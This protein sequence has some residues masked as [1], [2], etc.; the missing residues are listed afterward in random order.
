[1]NLLDRIDQAAAGSDMF[2]ES[3][4]VAPMWFPTDMAV[5]DFIVK[6]TGFG[7]VERA[8]PLIGAIV[9]TLDRLA[10]DHLLVDLSRDGEAALERVYPD[11]PIVI[12]GSVSSSGL[13][14]RRITAA[15]RDLLPRGELTID[16]CEHDQQREVIA[17]V[18]R[19]IER[20]SRMFRGLSRGL[21]PARVRLA[22][23]NP[24]VYVSRFGG[25][26]TTDALQSVDLTLDALYTG[27]AEAGA[28]AGIDWKNHRHEA[29]RALGGLRVIGDLMPDPAGSSL[30]G[31]EVPASADY[32]DYAGFVDRWVAEDEAALAAADPV[33]SSFTDFADD[34]HAALFDAVRDALSVVPSVPGVAG[35]RL[36]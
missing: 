23:L 36:G 7:A 18:N 17:A 8:R 32:S 22:I 34:R 29:E 9:E 25:V 26:R 3:S 13:F 5:F 28:I 24:D 15:A 14:E 6:I 27:L 33:D 21:V 12:S 16:W 11:D 19:E 1:V 10:A 2:D 31:V 4:E 35:L 20:V 30:E